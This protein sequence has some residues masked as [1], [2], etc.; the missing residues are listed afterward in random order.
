[1]HVAFFSQAWPPER[2]PNGVVSYVH[3]MREELRLRHRVSNF[4]AEL[5]WR[6]RDH[7]LARHS[8][9]TVVAKTLEEYEAAISMGGKPR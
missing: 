2:H 8:S 3:W 5:G 7:V 4:T 6:A 9:S 1:M